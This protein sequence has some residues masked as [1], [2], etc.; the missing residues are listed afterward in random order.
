[1]Q[2]VIVSNG[3]EL[4][5]AVANYAGQGY[6][7]AHKAEG[8]ATLRKAKEFNGVLALVAGILSCGIG[9][10]VYLVIYALQDDQ[11]VEIRVQEPG[12]GQVPPLSDDRRWWW[13]GQLRQ[14]QDAELVAP[15]G[16]PRSPE[17]AHW[18]DGAS[19]RP[20][21]EAEWQRL[22]RPRP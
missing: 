12:L 15:P 6:L 13:D 17:G 19:W 11:V 16:A 1:M 7:M 18:W 20:V 2:R 3:A 5:M 8:L 22:N 21:P 4:E 9:L 10:I 14:W